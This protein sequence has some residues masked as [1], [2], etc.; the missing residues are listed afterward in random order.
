MG[1]VA[2]KL[3]LNG[4]MNRW[5]YFKTQAES[6]HCSSPVLLPAW[7]TLLLFLAQ[8]CGDFLTRLFLSI[9]FFFKYYRG[10]HLYRLWRKYFPW[11]CAGLCSLAAAAAPFWLYCL[12][13]TLFTH[14]LLTCSA[15]TTLTFSFPCLACSSPKAF[16]SLE[17]LFYLL[18]PEDFLDYITMQSI[19]NFL[20][21][22]PYLVSSKSLISLT[23][24]ISF[25]FFT[26]MGAGADFC[27][28]HHCIIS[29]HKSVLCIVG[30]Q[31]VC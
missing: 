23:L 19:L 27:L 25:V 7:Y 31:H 28:F 5:L 13:R 20:V 10:S 1:W 15:V 16:T 26:S 18:F 6:N 30:I 11:T 4:W 9:L 22:F 12:I 24:C 14:T 8:I 21:P 2:K 17:S 3:A 29:I